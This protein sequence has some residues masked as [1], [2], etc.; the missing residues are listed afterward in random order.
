MNRPRDLTTHYIDAHD[1]IATLQGVLDQL[2]I[3]TQPGDKLK[4]ALDLQFW[5][6]AWAEL[7]TEH[8]RRNEL[9]STEAPL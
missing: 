5:N 6:D 1:A 2:L 9:M 4:W 7:E 8:P 3:E